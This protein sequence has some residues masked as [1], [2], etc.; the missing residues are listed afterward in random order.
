[1]RLTWH[2]AGWCND[3]YIFCHNRF[4][5]PFL[6]FC[7]CYRSFVYYNVREKQKL[8]KKKAAFPLFL[9]F[10]FPIVFLFWNILA[11]KDVCSGAVW[12]GELTSGRSIQS[13]AIV[14][15]PAMNGRL[16]KRAPEIHSIFEI[17]SLSVTLNLFFGS[18]SFDICLQVVP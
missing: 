18:N 13:A 3:E 12:I 1:M 15:I 8:G 17:E 4:Q 5:T 6:D 9:L 16:A 10:L 7:R 14:R 2:M 11:C